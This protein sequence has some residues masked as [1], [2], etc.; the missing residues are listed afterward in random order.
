M[1]SSEDFGRDILSAEN[2][3]LNDQ[4]I[5]VDFRRILKTDNLS[6]N[7]NAMDEL[8]LLS[9]RKGCDNNQTRKKVWPILLHANELNTQRKPLAWVNFLT[10]SFER[11]LKPRTV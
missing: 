7:K 3:L 6:T 9:A 2:D 11:I 10:T 5:D 4:N 8:R 1:T